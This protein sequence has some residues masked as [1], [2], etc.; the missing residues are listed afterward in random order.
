MPKYYVNK[1]AQPNGDHEV[2]VED[3]SHFPYPQNKLYLGNFNNCH[4]AVEEAKKH[5]P[6][7]ADG[8]YYCCKPCHTS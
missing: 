1:N 7:T 2:H 3:C 6:T 4:N 5:Y 8:C